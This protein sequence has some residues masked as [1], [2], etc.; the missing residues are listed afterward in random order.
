MKCFEE[1][2][3]YPQFLKYSGPIGA[4]HD[5]FV[6]LHNNRWIFCIPLCRFGC[7]RRD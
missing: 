1:K 6:F 7:T 4:D 3:S 2:M 5:L